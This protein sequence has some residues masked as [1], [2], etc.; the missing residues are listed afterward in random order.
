[1]SDLVTVLDEYDME[2]YVKE[3]DDLD[4]QRKQ[5]MLDKLFRMGIHKPWCN[6]NHPRYTPDG[7]GWDG[8]DG[9]S[10]SYKG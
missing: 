5:S 10:E 6:C 4:E 3:C 8:Y 1:M 9:T 7:Y 2:D